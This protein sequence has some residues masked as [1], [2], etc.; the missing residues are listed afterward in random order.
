MTYTTGAV[1]SRTPTLFSAPLRLCSA[2]LLVLAFTAAAQETKLLLDFEQQT[3]LKGWEFKKGSA[4][5]ST[6]H[7]THGQKCLKVSA[8]E[9]MSSWRFPKDW[10]G[11]DSLD[12][13]MFNDGTEAVTGYLLV[14]DGPWKAKGNSYWNRHNGGFNLL[15]GANTVSISVN[16]LYRGEAGGRNHDIKTNIDPHEIVRIDFGFTCKQATAS[17]FID[18]L[19][20]VK[21]SRPEGILAFD[22][23][24]PSQ[25]IFPGFAPITWNTVYGKSG[26]TAGLKHAAWGPN[27]ARDDGFPTRLYQDFV[28]LTDTEF[29]ADVPNGKYNVW[30]VFDDLG[31]WG[32]E[33]ARF[34][35]RWVENGG[36]TVWSETR[37]PDDYLFHFENIEPKSGDNVWDVYMK[38]LFEPK[39]FSA[40]AAGGKLGLTFRGEGVSACKVA[41][42]IIYPEAKKE[43]AE[44]WIAEVEARNRKEFETKAVLLGPKEPYT[45][46]VYVP[47]SDF[48]WGVPSLADDISL[49]DKCDFEQRKLDR[50]AARGQRVSFTF[51]VRREKFSV[52][53]ALQSK[54]PSE[55]SLSVSDLKGPG[56]D[57]PASQVDVRYVWHSIR[58]NCNEIAFQISP[59]G[60]RRFGGS[61]LWMVDQKQ[62]YAGLNLTR[63]FW[64]T[65]RVPE[66]A[67]LGSYR[68]EIAIGPLTFDQAPLRIPISLDVL[69]LTLDEPDF[70]MGYY[71]FGVP[72]SEPE[73]RRKAMRDLF[74]ILR[75]NGM[76][77]I[78][79]GPNIRFSGFEAD[80]KPKLDFAACDEYFQIARECGFTREFNSYGGPG[81]V[82]GLHDGYVIGE[83]GHKWEKQTGKPFPE[84]LKIVWGAVKEHAEK[85]HWPPIAYGFT[86]EPRVIETARA[87]VELMKTYREA[88]PFVKIGGSYSVKWDESPLEKEIQN[89]FKTLV[90]SALNLHTQTDL[91]KAKEFG[92]ELYIYNQGRTRFS[93]GAYQWAEFHKGIRGRIQWHL[94]ALHGYQFFDLDGR[95]PDTAMINWGRNEI[96]P[97]IHLA[98]CR[99]GADDFRFAVTLWNRAQ[100][101]KDTPEGKAAIA[102]L[103]DVS[104]KIP[105]GHNARPDGFM[106]DETFRNTCAQHLR[107]LMRK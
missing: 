87:Q 66:S 17:V 26:V 75:E 16:G 105:I 2:F 9:Y 74:T 93:F 106:D 88:V 5:L 51:A 53:G 94:L 80:G 24:P 72:F 84:L 62:P 55:L 43:E 90:W 4:A 32:G 97:T 34:S 30:L 95:E 29:V 6:E 23:G 28:Q 45:N 69:D 3:D 22:F 67:K 103:E 68:G 48:K 1:N 92:R 37:D 71:G 98:R 79:G 107:A 18:N 52:K 83:T 100:K 49:L 54:L 46:Q 78:C 81:M 35:K 15:P 7:V 38:Y 86:D 64:I 42:L 76:N 11:Y 65:V 73:K 25:V 41:A 20:L 59:E 39:R 8:N 14:G 36:K 61:G 63:Q 21:E 57:I 56:C 58:R 13:D 85:E 77:C 44:K 33:Q 27:S 99:E 31:Y 12:I 70:A 47:D 60:L 40:V 19:R 101:A 10:S 89:I 96:I 82:E 50:V 102:F 91:D 104:A